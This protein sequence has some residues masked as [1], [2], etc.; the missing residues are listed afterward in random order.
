MFDLSE[1]LKKFKHEIQ[2]NLNKE[3][4]THVANVYL[5]LKDEVKQW[6]DTGRTFESIYITDEVGKVQTPP[7]GNYQLLIESKDTIYDSIPDSAV[8]YVGI[9]VPYVNTL[10]YGDNGLTAKAPLRHTLVKSK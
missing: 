2:R 1:T 4:K 9:A 10:E 3:I 5:T 7:E 6:S 8:F